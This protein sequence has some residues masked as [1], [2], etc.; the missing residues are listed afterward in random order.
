[1]AVLTRYRFW[2]FET[3]QRKH[4]PQQPFGR[5]ELVTRQFK[6]LLDSRVSSDGDGTSPDPMVSMLLRALK[7]VVCDAMPDVEMVPKECLVA[8]R[9]TQS[10][11]VKRQVRVL[12]STL[13]EKLQ[14]QVPADHPI[15]T[16]LPRHGANCLTR[17]GI[18]ENSK[19]AEQRRTGKRC[20]KPA[21]EIGT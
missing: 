18:E 21:L 6:A 7:N 16:W 14:P 9:R 4:T 11:E 1:M 5:Q 17:Y 19:T 8:K 12:K 15:L 13:E 20:L 3:A 10:K 2:S